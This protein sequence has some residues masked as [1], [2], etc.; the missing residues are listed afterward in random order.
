VV[1]RVNEATQILLFLDYDGTLTPIVASPEMAVLSPQAREILKQISRHSLFKLAIITGRS[2]REIKALVGLENVTYAGNHGLEIE[3]LPRHCQGRSLKT[4]SYIHPLAVEYQPFM[5]S[6]EEKLEETLAGIEGILIEDKGLTLSVHYRLV[7][8]TEVGT[9][10]RLFFEALA[11]S[12]RG[13]KAPSNSLF[14]LTKEGKG[15]EKA[16]VFAPLKV[17]EGKKVL[18]VRPPVEWNKGKAIE[19]LLHVYDGKDSLA[20]FAGDDAT[21]EDGF[22]FLR[23]IGGISIFIGKEKTSSSAD[24]Y[25]DSP[26]DLH[27]WLKRLL[28]VTQCRF[29]SLYS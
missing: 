9:V 21:D 7:K 16:E 5:R 6:V 27:Y 20:I 8:E 24:Y 13:R 2:L 15:G 10:R 28:R 12:L 26:E 3:C 22:R 25:L 4:I 1:K 19:W 29:G 18:E 17:T 14:P 23:Q 11:S